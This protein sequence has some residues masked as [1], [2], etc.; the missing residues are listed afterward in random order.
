MK[1]IAEYVKENLPDINNEVKYIYINK[2]KTEY[3]ITSSG[4]VYSLNY[5][6]TGKKRKLKTRKN[7]SGYHLIGIRVNGK[8]YVKQVH[9]LV[10]DA[11]IPNPENKPQ[12][13]H[14]NGNKDDNSVN[15]LEW[16]TAKEN[17]LH[18]IKTNL[19]PVGEKSY[20]AKITEKQA[21]E[22]SELLVENKL[23][24]PEICKKCKVSYSTVNDIK[25]KKSWKSL[26]EKYDFTKHTIKSKT[27]T[28]GSKN[29]LS[30]INE[31]KVEKICGMITS[32]NL[33]LSEIAKIMGVTY[34]IV[35]NIYNGSTWKAV[36]SKYDF[37]KYKPRRQK[38]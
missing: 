26:T 6:H 4:D 2:I 36:S 21:I 30:T 16:V 9:R 14:I 1:K 7:H 38:G 15:N 8:C 22:I 35:Q 28:F 3:Q 33:S 18:A 11:F 27:G 29:N 23:S 13:N 12:V 34:K 32:N 24:V 10:A 37:S 25:R 19:K 5:N 17:I 31:D 20:L